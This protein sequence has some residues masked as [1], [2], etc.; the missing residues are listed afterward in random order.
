MAQERGVKAESSGS[1]RKREHLFVYLPIYLSIFH[2]FFLSAK[3]SACLSVCPVRL[4]R[5]LYL[6]EKAATVAQTVVS[7]L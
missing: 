6:R 7:T 2:S 5:S 4:S 3:L 1:G